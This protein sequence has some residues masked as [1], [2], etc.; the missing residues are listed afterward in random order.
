MA[1]SAVAVLAT[2]GYFAYQ[3]FGPK[4][5]EAPPKWAP[6]KG[7]GQGSAMVGSADGSIE[8]SADGG[9][10]GSTDGSGTGS[11]AG[12]AEP[13]THKVVR[14]EVPSII[15]LTPAAATAKL[16]ALG[17]MDT[18]L[19]MPPNLG[20][21]YADEKRDIV[22]VGAI[23]A[24][25]RDPGQILMSNAKLRVVIERNTYEHGGVEVENEWHRMPDL[26]GLPLAR[27]R[28]I[29]RDRGFG[30]DE[31]EIGEART[32]CGAGLVCDQRPKADTRKFASSRGE[33]NIGN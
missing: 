32:S 30:E 8:G 22:P 20:C 1:M 7:S 23:C 13:P 21:D 31:F 2:G 16:V 33:L 14:L 4:P 17:F 26:V 19:E 24:Q 12:S 9:H 3:E 18:V 25:E 27:A 29:L 28:A 10:P 11:E 6:G 15:G 5:K